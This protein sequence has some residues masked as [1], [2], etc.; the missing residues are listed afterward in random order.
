MGTDDDPDKLILRPITDLLKIERRKQL[1]PNLLHEKGVTTIVAPPGEGK[2]TATFSMGLSIGIG[3]WGGELIKRRPLVWIPGEDQ[4]GLRAIFEAWTKHNPDRHPDAHYME[5]PT[6]FSDDREVEKLA[7][8]VEERGIVRPVFV[9]DALADILGDLNEDKA[10]DINQVYRNV[11]RVVKRFD[12][13]FV[14]LHHSGWDEKRE[15][16]STAIR[17]KS[18]ILIQIVRFDPEAGHVELKH[19]KLRGG[20]RLEQFFLRVK[21]IP[22]EG[23][24]E[25]IPI[26]TGPLTEFDKVMTEPVEMEEQHAREL[27]QVMVQHFPQGATNSQLEKRSGMKDSTF[28]RALGCA[29]KEKGWLVGG[30]G[31]GKKYNLNPNGCWKEGG[32]DKGSTSGPGHTPYRGVDPLDPKEVRSNGPDWTQVGPLD[33]WTQPPVAATQP[34][35]SRSISPMKSMK[36]KVPPNQRMACWR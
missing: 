35:P 23:Y 24:K 18:N 2:T 8:L 25:P 26:V 36:H 19:N 6:D 30:G 15:R 27:V 1:V 7:V 9:A 4:E 5:E 3:L 17:A 21:L 34:Q 10:H 22:V 32:S 20:K 33:P 14:V 28:K 11:W 31:R 13:A 29:S 16:G 12:A